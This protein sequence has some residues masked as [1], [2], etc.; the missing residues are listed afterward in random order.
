MLRRCA[1][2]ARNELDAFCC[3]RCPC[4]KGLYGFKRADHIAPP[5]AALGSLAG[6]SDDVDTALLQR[7]LLASVH[8]ASWEGS[9]VCKI[10]G[11]Q[12]TSKTW[13]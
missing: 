9:S 7:C 1:D 6:F 4:R 11:F 13:P 3:W 5:D 10:Y 2:T 8:S 12:L